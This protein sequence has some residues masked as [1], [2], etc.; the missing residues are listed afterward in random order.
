VLRKLARP[1]G[2][3]V[4]IAWRGAF[5][6]RAAVEAVA[7]VIAGRLSGFAAGAAAGAV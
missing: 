5:P 1:A 7:D 4:R 6:R 2:R 3:T